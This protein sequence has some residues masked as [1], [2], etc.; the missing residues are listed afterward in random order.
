M[1]DLP[2]L[3]GLSCLL[4]CN[5]EPPPI[6]QDSTTQ[7][8]TPKIH[9]QTI[10]EVQTTLANIQES[11]RQLI[12]SQKSIGDMKLEAEQICQQSAFLKGACVSGTI[13]ALM[14]GAALGSKA[15]N[16]AKRKR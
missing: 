10:Q 6:T 2:M 1:A 8:P 11:Q 7:N 12:Q 5:S 16:A 4:S 15:R 14:V 9:D 13:M 3:M